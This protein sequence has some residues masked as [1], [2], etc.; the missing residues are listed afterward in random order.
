VGRRE[1]WVWSCRSCVACGSFDT[2]TIDD[3]LKRMHSEGSIASPGFMNPEGVVIWHEAARI[4]FKKTLDHND[5][6]KFMEK[7]EDL[8]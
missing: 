5:E 6:H 1:T 3:I 4:L 7:V 8:R 2:F